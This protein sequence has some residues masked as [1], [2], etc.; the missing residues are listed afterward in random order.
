[1][2]TEAKPASVPDLARVLRQARTARGLELGS[3]SEQT[4]IPLDQLQDLESG[5]VDR[6]PDRVAILKA[7]SR[8]AAFLSLPGDQFVM[9][10]VE[11]WPNAPT[12]APPVVVVHDGPANGNRATDTAVE[13]LAPAAP[14]D[15]LSTRAVPLS[16]S[17]STGPPTSVGLPIL[18]GL[19]HSTAQVPTV[20]AD[21]GVTPAVRREPVNGLGIVVVRSLVVVAT[22]LLVVGTAWL[23]VNRLH[24]QWL[25]DL[26]VP[27]TSN[28][29]TGAPTSTVKGPP[30]P[31][32][33]A[34]HTTTK[35]ALQLVSANGNQASFNVSA[36]LF[37]VRVSATGGATW[38][39]ISGPL[40]SNPVFAGILQSGQSHVVTA[41]HQLTV[42]IGST[43]ARLAV[44][45]GHRV[46]GTYVPPGAP[47][48]MTFTTK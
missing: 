41:N 2:G 43:A 39:S 14:P 9:T 35:P 23:V 46:I 27:Y 1:M 16:V 40:S 48:T 17:T 4:G 8:Y 18:Q 5:T 19:H 20:M 47:F 30:A 21:T 22:L 12:G 44:Q 45:V 15:D 28:G 33:S 37:D 32:K 36:P 10:L 42:Q 24:P 7:L 11:H 31:T 26:H 25:A 29:I 38:V 34:T 13:M 3:I 6:L